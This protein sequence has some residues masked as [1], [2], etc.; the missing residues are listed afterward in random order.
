MGGLIRYITK[1]A[2]PNEF[3]LTLAANFT[4]IDESDDKGT[5]INAV[6]NIPLLQ[7]KLGLRV[8]AYYR[9]Q[10]GILDIAAPRNEDDVDDQEDEG[11]RVKLN[12]YPTERLEVAFM[13]KLYEI[14]LWW[15]GLRLF[16]LREYGDHGFQIFLMVAQTSINKQT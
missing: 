5:R 6:A 1:D 13:G 16:C 9:D 15:P 3:D 10:P 11:V 12:W 14:Q 7:D 2:N 4:S 8:S